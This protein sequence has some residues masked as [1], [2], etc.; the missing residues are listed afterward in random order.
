MSIKTHSKCELCLPKDHNFSQYKVLTNSD[1]LI[2][3]LDFLGIAWNFKRC[4]AFTQK[5]KRCLKNPMRKTLL[6]KLH[7]DMLLKNCNIAGLAK[8]LHGSDTEQRRRIKKYVNKIKYRYGR[9]WIT[10]YTKSSVY[11]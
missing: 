11:L 3:I 2:Q 7:F 4:V 10:Y 9:G 1:L 5:K 6:C 8:I